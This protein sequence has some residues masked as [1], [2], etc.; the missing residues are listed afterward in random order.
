MSDELEKIKTVQKHCLIALTKRLKK[1][2]GSR[3]KKKLIPTYYDFII[4]QLFFPFNC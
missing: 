1:K 2:K 3:A 4:T